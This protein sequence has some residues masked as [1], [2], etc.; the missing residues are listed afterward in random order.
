MPSKKVSSKKPSPKKPVDPFAGLK[1]AIVHDWLIGGGA[2]K[3]VYQLHLM[4]PNAPIYTSYATDEWRGRM[5]GT[6]RTGILQHWPFSRLRKF[7]PILRIWWFQRLDLSG[8][9]LVISSSGAEAKGINVPAGTLHINYCH[10]PTHY[11]W[12]RYDAYME[13]PGFGPLDALARIGLRTLVGP[14]RD[15]DYKAAQK[16][17]YM[18]AN[19][20]H[21]AA[22]IAKYYQR[23]AD[24]VFPP[25]DIGRFIPTKHTHER[26]GFI[27]AG[28]Q[29]PYKRFDLAVAACS[30]I[31]APLKVIGKGPDHDRLTAMAG[32]SIRFLQANDTEMV[33]HFQSAAA[34]I[35]PGVDDFGIVAVEAMAA[36]TPVI[37]YKGGGASDYIVEGVTGTYF[38]KQTAESLAEALR[39]FDA[40][41]FDSAKISRH[42]GKF[43]AD[44]FVAKMQKL[45]VKYHKKGPRKASA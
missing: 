10:A 34:F 43:A 16:P 36:G 5:D 12:S 15:W 14:L 3:V 2:E 17:D 20:T 39:T 13:H 28:R 37:A 27:M 29:T 35:F 7:L 11:Y 4:F 19:S 42:A 25:V 23:Q 30:R 24:V 31:N 44:K 22:E 40:T 6:V 26:F 32:Q 18:I 9:D 8:Y 38:H 41:S 21:T 33:R 45:L 1:V